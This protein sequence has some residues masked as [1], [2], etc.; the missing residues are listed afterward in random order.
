MERR[1]CHTPELMTIA[2]A[3]IG[4]VSTTGGLQASY[5]LGAP[6]GPTIVCLATLLFALSSAAA[7]ISRLVSQ[8]GS[9]ASPQ[10]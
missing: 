7:R 6:T 3:I 10:G 9:E 5:W 4:E 1:F 8:T 2:A